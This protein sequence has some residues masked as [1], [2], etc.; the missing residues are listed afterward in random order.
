MN[1]NIKLGFSTGCCYR[2][3]DPKSK[4]IT[5][6]IA[7]TECN[8]IELC[9]VKIE[10]LDTKISKNDVKRFSYLSIHAPTD[11]I[12]YKDNEETK[13]ILDKLEALNKNLGSSYVVFH[14]DTINDFSIFKKYNFNAV[15]ENM[16]NRK[17]SLQTVDEFKILFEKYP[18][19]NMVL[20]LNHCLSNDNTFRL[21]YDFWNNLKDKIKY[22]HISGFI[23]N[24]HHPLFNSNQ[25]FI[26]DFIK[27]KNLPIIVESLFDNKNDF[28]KEISYINKVLCK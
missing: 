1:S 23:D 17:K 26:I 11:D 2:T 10:R 24:Y 16:D 8:A 27:N 20:D 22:F 6:I 19:L 12:I 14:P 25:D 5:D 3:I 15:F 21:A 28:E 13:I 4:E 18:K 7:K 9:F